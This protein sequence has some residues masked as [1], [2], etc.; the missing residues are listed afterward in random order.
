MIRGVFGPGTIVLGGGAVVL[1]GF[2]AIGLFLPG[3]WDATAEVHVHA[4]LDSV[5]VLL[6]SPDGWRRWTPWPDSVAPGPGPRRGPGASMTWSDSELGSGTFRVE[7]VGGTASSDG[8]RTIAY[9][10]EVEG[11]AGET[12]RTLGTVTLRA[13][14]D[15]TRVVWRE[16]GDLGNNPL[17]G[18][19][20][21][22]MER[23]QGTEMGKSLDRL[24]EVAGGGQITSSPGPTR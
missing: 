17:M 16:E 11:V 9:T 3:T 20:A 8:P 1:I 23:A 21:L 14:G 22:S 5:Q 2:L 12:L 4:P 18:F 7:E 13:M 19:W 15:S 10:V 6:D 24:A